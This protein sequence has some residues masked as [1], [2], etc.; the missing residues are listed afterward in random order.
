MCVYIYI[1]ILYEFNNIYTQKHHPKTV[2]HGP[3][4]L[5]VHDDPLKVQPDPSRETAR[6]VFSVLVMLV[7]IIIS[8]TGL[9]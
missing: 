4:V 7:T 8:I 5:S 9:V 2:S 1:H 6:E 3:T